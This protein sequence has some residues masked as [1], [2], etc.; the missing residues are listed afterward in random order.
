MILPFECCPGRLRDR[1]HDELVGRSREH[2]V[3]F[4]KKSEL[5]DAS[6]ELRVV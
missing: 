1:E 4:Q 5:F 6:C 2:A 3:E